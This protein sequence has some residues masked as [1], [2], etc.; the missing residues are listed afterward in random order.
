MVIFCR[1]QRGNLEQYSFRFPHSLILAST[2]STTQHPDGRATVA[3]LI[4]FR[5]WRDAVAAFCHDYCRNSTWDGSF[6]LAP[7]YIESRWPFQ[8]NFRVGTCLRPVRL[9]SAPVIHGT[10]RPVL[11]SP[12][13]HA[14]LFCP[15]RLVRTTVS[16]GAGLSARY[17]SSAFRLF[18]LT[19]R[20]VFYVL[21]LSMLGFSLRC[22]M[23]SGHLCA[24][25][26]AGASRAAVIYSVCIPFPSGA[27]CAPVIYAETSVAF[28]RA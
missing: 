9:S 15:V 25:F 24:L 4:A 10:F 13:I 1:S 26:S 28:F 27:S 6:G 23:R 5:L 20:P 16:H 22:V 21:R 3:L 17:A 12:V 19:F 2:F 18:T 8:L 7:V 14:W 11:R